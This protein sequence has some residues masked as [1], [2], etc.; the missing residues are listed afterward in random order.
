MEPE[1]VVE[2]EAVVRSIRRRRTQSPLPEAAPPGNARAWMI[3]A[4]LTMGTAGLMFDGYLRDNPSKP[5]LPSLS[6]AT[7][8]RSAIAES[9]DSLQV[10]VGWD[11]S[12]SDSA[13]APDSVRVRVIP[14]RSDTLVLTQPAHQLADTAYLPVPPVGQAMRGFSCVAARHGIQPLEEVCAPWKYVR[15]RT[16]PP[17]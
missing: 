8:V 13:G 7:D 16:D 11:L 4:T 6:Q 15:S 17:M 12:L 5:P 1:E 9:D 3:Y 10:V 2:P 14:E